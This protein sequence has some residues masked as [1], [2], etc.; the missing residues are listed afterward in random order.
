MDKMEQS[1]K[2]LGY[3]AGK[4]AGSWVIDG[5]TSE[6]TALAILKGYDEGD[7]QVM[8][9]QPSPLSGEWADDP[10]IADVLANIADDADVELDKD[11]E[12]DD[13]LNIYEV[14]YSEGF[15]NEVIR[16]ANAVL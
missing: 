13:L 9:M 7:S 11:G 15:W 10:T 2:K 8:D 14:S 3:D 6:E 12:Y 16:S 5:N 4:A 1:A